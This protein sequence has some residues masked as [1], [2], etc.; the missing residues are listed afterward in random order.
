MEEIYANKIENLIDYTSKL[1]RVKNS[2]IIEKI[3]YLFIYISI[4]YTWTTTNNIIEIYIFVMT[5]YNTH[6]IFYFC[7]KFFV[8]SCLRLK[9]AFGCKSRFIYILEFMFYGHLLRPMKIWYGHVEQV[10]GILLHILILSAQVCYLAHIYTSNMW[11]KKNQIGN[12][13]DMSF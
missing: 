6:E 4:N 10:D 2:C 8:S 7:T 11:E 9:T 5:L 12:L 13:Q 3:T 1:Q